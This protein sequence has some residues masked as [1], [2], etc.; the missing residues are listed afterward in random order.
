MKF[1]IYKKIKQC[2]TAIETAEVGGRFM[3]G[4]PA[5]NMGID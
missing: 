1:Q 4:K 5:M 2:N 3:S